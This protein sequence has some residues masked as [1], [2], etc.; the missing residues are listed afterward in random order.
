[1]RCVFCHHD[2]I[3]KHLFFQCRFA[4]SIWSIIQAASCLYPPTSVAN[5]FGWLHIVDLRFRTLIS[6][7][8]LAV[9]WSLWL[10]RNDKVFDNKNYFLLQVI[11]RYTGMLRLWPHIQQ[12]ENRDLFT[13]VRT[14]LEATVRDI[15][16]HMGGRIIYGLDHHHLLRRST[17]ARK[18][19]VFN[20]F[21]LNMTDGRMCE[22]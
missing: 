5:I 20:L 6:V 12:M 9:I 22:S 7:E 8:A 3:I 10:C 21:G 14:R 13:E 15:F 4:R 2:E 11:Y 17:I 16:P 19:Y 1:M 18:R